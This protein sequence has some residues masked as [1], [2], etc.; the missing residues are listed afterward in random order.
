[1]EPQCD[2]VATVQFMVCEGRFVPRLCTFHSIRDPAFAYNVLT[3]Y[4]S[5][6]F[7]GGDVLQNKKLPVDPFQHPEV[8][9]EMHSVRLQHLKKH[10]SRHVLPP[11]ARIACID[12]AS[13]QYL[14]PIMD[15]VFYLGASLLG[16]YSYLNG[17][18][19]EYAEMAR[20]AAIILNNSYEVRVKYEPM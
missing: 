9:G 15:S 8:N 11:D 7:Y 10:L 17:P 6:Q 13:F 5:L 16:P 19:P 1:M 2:Y 3:A 14:L 20:R 12:M 18:K 4:T